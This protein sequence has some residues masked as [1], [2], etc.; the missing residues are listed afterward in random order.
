ML[1]L[2]LA[3]GFGSGIVLS[4]LAPL[5]MMMIGLWAGAAAT[6]VAA[7]VGAAA[8]AGTVG[9]VSALLFLV[10]TALPAL[11]VANRSLLWRENQD[12][13]IE[14]YPP[15]EVLAWLTAIGLALLLCGAA[16]MADHP[17]GVRGFVAEMIGKALDLIAAELPPD[18]RADAVTWWTPL[19]PA[20]TVVSWLLMAVANACGAQAL[21]VRMGKN[22]RPKPAYREL[23]LPNWPAA[24]LAVTGLLGVAAGGDVGFVAANLAVVLLVPFVFLGLAGIHRFAATK[25]QSRL[26]LGL[27]YGLLILAFG[28]AAIIVALIGLVRFWR[29]RFRR[30]SSGGGM[31]G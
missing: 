20:M 4:Y 26:I 11:V 5:P 13:S 30:P 18:R 28:W 15:G 23:M 14:W 6:L 31:E 16:L 22:H 1:F 29:L 12:G 24:A 17:D 21:L 27:V 25:P 2:S 10:A 8:V 7:V 9:G 3:K 19:F